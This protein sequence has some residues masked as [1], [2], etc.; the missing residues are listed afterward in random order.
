MKEERIWE[1]RV[2]VRRKKKNRVFLFRKS[3][4]NRW[5]ERKWERVCVER[6]RGKPKVKVKAKLGSNVYC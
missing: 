4:M 1:V 2:K 3:S 6:I 5:K